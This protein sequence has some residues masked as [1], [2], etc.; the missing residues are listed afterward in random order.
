M[1]RYLKALLLGVCTAVFVACAVGCAVEKG[2]AIEITDGKAQFGQSDLEVQ[3][4]ANPTT[5]YE[6]TYTIDGT[7]VQATG[8]QYVATNEGDEAKAGEGGTHTFNFKA[9]GSG[10]ATI[11]FTYARSWEASEDDQT[12]VLHVATENGNFTQLEEVA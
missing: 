6:W 7:V 4:D 1:Q 11:T 9:D 10:E 8:D 5:G 3:L 2:T 12:V